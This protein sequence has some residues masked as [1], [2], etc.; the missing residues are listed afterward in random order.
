[1]QVLKKYFIPRVIPSNR[2]SVYRKIFVDEQPEQ[3]FRI[4]RSSRQDFYFVE[5]DNV[6]LKDQEGIHIWFCKFW[7][8]KFKKMNFILINRIK[9]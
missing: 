9:N 3:N 4:K 7:K 5:V 2:M 8:Y 6:S 1:M